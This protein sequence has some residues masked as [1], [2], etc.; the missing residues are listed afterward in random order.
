MVRFPNV[1]LIIDNVLRQRSVYTH[2]IGFNRNIS[3]QTVFQQPAT[4]YTNIYKTA[5]A[6]ATLKASSTAISGKKSLIV[7]F[8]RSCSTMTTKPSIYLT[9]PDFAENSVTALRDE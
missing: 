7:K 8:K 3:R 2:A 1:S 4:I 6:T 9:R 5:A